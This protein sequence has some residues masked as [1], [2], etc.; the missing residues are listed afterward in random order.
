MQT[1]KKLFRLFIILLTLVLTGYFFFLPLLKNQADENPAEDPEATINSEKGVA[2]PVKAEPARMGELIIR[3]S[4]TGR[5]EAMR[6][7]TISPKISGE[8]LALPL[9]EGQRVN[10]GDLLLQLDAREYELALAEAQSALLKAQGEFGIWN[11]SRA[12]QKP[13]AA[14]SG[15]ET[16]GGN[17]KSS[18]AQIDAVISGK[19]QREVSEATTGLAQAR[20][21]VARA[22][23]N[24]AH[25]KITAPFGGIVGNVAVTP[26]QSVSA[27]TECLQLLDLSTVKV[28]VG[29]LENEVGFLVPGRQAVVTFPAFPDQEFRGTIET[30]NPLID[31]ETK[32]CRVT[33]HLANPD[34]KIK[35]G[36]FAYVNLDAQIF[37]NRFLVPKAAILLRDNRK[38]LFIVRENLAKWS[39][40][41]TGLEN[42]DFAEILESKMNLEPGE[43]VITEGHYTLTHDARVQVGE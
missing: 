20:V 28:A 43:P 33:V 13:E 38:L 17:G 6:K 23:L 16:D 37:K 18:E 26:G 32:T 19:H 14:D 4:A 21:G 35:D 2:L 15:R 5:T 22:E 41:T 1:F 40:V 8:L 25:A 30:I 9:H 12:Q 29:V 3:I 31:P 42:E 10:R 36:M 24:L 39:Y 11:Y 7:I 27:S 34:Y